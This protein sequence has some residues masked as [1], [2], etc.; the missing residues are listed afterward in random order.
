MLDA[1]MDLLHTVAFY[2]LFAAILIDLIAF[3]AISLLIKKFHR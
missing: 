3:F 2:R 1:M